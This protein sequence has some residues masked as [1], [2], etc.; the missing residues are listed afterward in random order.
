MESAD[1]T[2]NLKSVDG[3]SYAIRFYRAESFLP[4]RFVSTVIPQTT[5]EPRLKRQ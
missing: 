4:I 1:R 5:G 3:D 2:T